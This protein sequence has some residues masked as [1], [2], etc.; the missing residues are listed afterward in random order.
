MNKIFD[1]KLPLEER[2]DYLLKEMTIE[3]KVG[4]LPA[5]QAA[6]PRLDIGEYSVG[7]EGA[8]GLLVRRYYDQWPGGKSTVFP[9]PIGMSCTFDKNLLGRVGDVISTEARIWYEKDNRTKWLTLWFPTIDMERDPRWGRNEEA[10]GEDPHLAGKLAAALIRGVQGNHPYYLKASCA[11]KHFYG[12]NV[13]KDRGSTSTNISERLKHEYYL[14]VF[15]YAFVEGRAHSLMT[16]YNEING[17]PCI[18]NPE[19]VTIVKGEWG[20]DGHIV[21]DGD[22]LLQ[23]ITLHKY[24]ETPAQ[25]IALALKNGVDCFPEQ[26]TENVTNAA[27]DALKEGLLTVEDIDRAVANTLRTRFRLG[28]F[29]PDSVNPYS[30]IKHDRLC[31]H[32][33]SAVALETSKKAV[34]L[35]KNDGILPLDAKKC[36]KILMLGDLAEANF[37]DWYSGKPPHVTTPFNA[38][39]KKTSKSRVKA[40]KTH[41]L[42][43]IFNEVEKAWLR[44]DEKGAVTFD[45]DEDTRAVFEEI[46]WGFNAVSYRDGTSGKYLNLANDP[47][48]EGEFILACTSEVVW[49]WFTM[50]QFMRD[51]ITGK[52]LGHGQTFGNRYNEEDNKKIK[53]LVKSLRSDILTNAMAPIKYEA[54]RSDTVI[55]ALGNHPLINGR[56]CYDRPSINFPKRWKK[57]IDS[58]CS[59][60]KNVVLMLIA[61]Y[62]YAFPKEEKSFRAVLYTAHGEQDV[63]AALADVV[64]GD[65]NPAGRTSMTWYQSEKDLPDINDYDIINNPRTYMYFDK[66]VQYPFGHGLSYTTFDYS[67]LKIE[68]NDDG[69]TVSCKVKNTGELAGDEVV[70]L[71]VTL[72]ETPVKAPVKMLCGFERVHFEAGESKTIIFAVPPEDTA[73]YDEEAAAFS[74][75]PKTVT[76]TIGASSKDIR[77][78][79]DSL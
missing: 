37:A 69:H 24:C 48:R 5:R 12:N 70:Q 32:E 49:G 65:Y 16:A 64:F 8:H 2:I 57:I 34:V 26:K 59:V 29:D 43:V 63:G 66:P 45:G 75:K 22:D 39:R 25:A 55:L 58:V 30:K 4:L 77:L 50:E 27:L 72:N 74:I 79:G 3:E 19:N 15:K 71:Y 13:E 46:D 52:F 76:F 23:T 38:I 47:Q 44:I 7:A 11:P 40:M 78:K 42:C 54:E 35:L 61:G 18:A 51:E 67:D 53:N 17:V 14:K 20:C 41:D 28:Q 6:I 62:P 1:H 68:K 36:G 33:H 56:E 9:Q 31:G 10:Y 21:S 60:N 73:L